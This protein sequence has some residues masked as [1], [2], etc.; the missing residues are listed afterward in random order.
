MLFASSLNY[1]LVYI[2][3]KSIISFA[4]INNTKEGRIHSNSGKI[5]IH[6]DTNLIDTVIE[7]KSFTIKDQTVV[8][9]ELRRSSTYSE[10][11][12]QQSEIKTDGEVKRLI[13][14]SSIKVTFY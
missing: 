10:K 13:V 5:R 7:I 8:E 1:E 9:S 4:H 3:L 2:I 12:M 14:N 6:E 11:S